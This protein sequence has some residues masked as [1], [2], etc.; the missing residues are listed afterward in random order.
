MEC[1]KRI[2][3]IRDVFFKIPEK[4]PV[5]FEDVIRT[6]PML[7]YMAE[8][9]YQIIPAIQQELGPPDHIMVLI[10]ETLEKVDCKYLQD[11]QTKKSLENFNW[12]L[13]FHPEL[14]D[15]VTLP[16][17]IH[18]I[19]KVYS[20]PLKNVNKFTLSNCHRV[21]DAHIYSVISKLPNLTSIDLT[22]ST[23]HIY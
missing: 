3:L 1:G 19:E 20:I 6:S 18:A 14:S 12:N 7:V 16:E 23:D 21:T 22:V 8:F 5:G 4:L 10:N 13:I 2:L 15:S 17:F 11:I 9:Y